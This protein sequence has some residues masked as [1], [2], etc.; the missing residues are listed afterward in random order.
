MLSRILVDGAYSMTPPDIGGR[1]C[2]LSQAA[3]LD[4]VCEGLALE[5]SRLCMNSL[6]F[7]VLQGSWPG[8]HCGGWV[9]VKEAFF[10]TLVFLSEDL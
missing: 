6:L 2:L 4:L 3:E 9:M 5:R 1:C 10:E 8:C 7:V